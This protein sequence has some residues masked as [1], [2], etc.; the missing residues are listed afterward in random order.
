MCCQNHYTLLYPR[1]IFVSV[2]AIRLTKPQ[3]II[4]TFTP[5][6]STAGAKILAPTTAPTF[7]AAALNPFKVDRH[8]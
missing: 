2:K 7:P 8:S 6:M 5:H 3:H 1:H 4:T